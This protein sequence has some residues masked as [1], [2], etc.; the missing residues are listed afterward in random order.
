MFFVYCCDLSVYVQ[1][2]V[3]TQIFA[4]FEYIPCYSS[5]QNLS[6]S[7]CIWS[8]TVIISISNYYLLSTVT[9]LMLA[10]MK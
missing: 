5:A 1:H 8:Y 9:W 3:D 10:T 6:D 7:H 4:E 2:W